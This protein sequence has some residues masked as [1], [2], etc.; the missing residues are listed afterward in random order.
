MNEFCPTQSAII[1]LGVQLDSGPL[2]FPYKDAARPGVLFQPDSNVDMTSQILWEAHRFFASL[3]ASAKVTV[4]TDFSDP[5]T[6]EDEQ[7]GTLYLATAML[8]GKTDE[9]I[10][11]SLR[12]RSEVLPVLLRNMP[13]NRNR[14]PYLRAW[15][16]MSGGLAERTEAISVADLKNLIAE[17]TDVKNQH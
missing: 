9:D 10:L 1:L 5:I 6:L 13:K 8:A 2:R 4:V 3:Q 12:K 14:V 7:I 11:S 16:V 15:Q 17:S